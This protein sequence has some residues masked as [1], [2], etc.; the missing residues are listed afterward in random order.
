MGILS[1]YVLYATKAFDMSTSITPSRIGALPTESR[2][3]L[4]HISPETR[5]AMTSSARQISLSR[6]QTLYERK[7]KPTGIFLIISGHI[8]MTFQSSSGMHHLLKVGAPGG[9]VGDLACVDGNP[10]PVFAEAMTPCTLEFISKAAFEKLREQY[11]DINAALLLYFSR[12][13][14]TM[15][16]MMEVTFLGH[17]DARVASRLAFLSREYGTNSLTLS[18]TDLG[19]MVGLSRQATN[20]SLQSL[21]AAGLIETQYGKINVLDFEALVSFIEKST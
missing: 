7:A 5:A 16:N 6:G 4:Q 17:V 8:R 9:V 13:S 1:H 19:L 12:L 18:Q 10:Y 20:A 15:I 14:R 21:S 3:W 11:P 2:S